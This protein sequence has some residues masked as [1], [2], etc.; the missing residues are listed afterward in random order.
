MNRLDAAEKAGIVLGLMGM[1]IT[2]T[3]HI[4]SLE[5]RLTLL[6]SQSVNAVQIENRLTRIETKLDELTQ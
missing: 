2:V 6:E 5:R 1:L 3:T 4:L